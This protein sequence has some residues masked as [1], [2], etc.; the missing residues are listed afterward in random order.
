MRKL[1]LRSAWS[2]KA[3]GNELVVVEQ[4][5]LAT[6]KTKDMVALLT[7]LKLNEVKTLIVVNEYEENVILASR[8]L[9]NLLIAL[10]TEI[11]VLDLASVDKVLIETTALDKIKEVLK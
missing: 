11:S 8:N 1:A 3:K 6:P 9:Q 2:Y 5:K 7:N 10:P 4:I